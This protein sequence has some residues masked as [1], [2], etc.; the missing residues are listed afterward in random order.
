[1]ADLYGVVSLPNQSMT[2]RL[3]MIGSISGSL[4]VTNTLTITLTPR[5]VLSGVV[6]PPEIT[7]QGWLTNPK[8]IVTGDSNIYEGALRVVPSTEDQVLATANKL[9]LADITVE[10]VPYFEVSNEYGTTI[11]I[12]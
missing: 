2:G 4:A 7:M 3:S 11:T 12:L 8:V 6:K 10:E 5:P 1:M 9:V